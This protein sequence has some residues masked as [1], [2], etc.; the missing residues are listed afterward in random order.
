MLSNEFILSPGATVEVRNW[1]GRGCRRAH[2]PIRTHECA[3]VPGC[4]Q[5]FEEAC[6][7]LGKSGALQLS[8]DQLLVA[9]RGRTTL[10]F[11]T[12]LL[13]P[14]LQGYQVSRAATLCS[15]CLCTATWVTCRA[16]NGWA[17]MM[18]T[19]INNIFMLSHV[20]VQSYVS[21]SFLH[22]TNQPNLTSKKLHN[23]TFPPKKINF[24]QISWYLY[25]IFPWPKYIYE[26]KTPLEMYIQFLFVV[27]AS[28]LQTVMA[29]WCFVEALQWHRVW[30]SHL[31]V[32]KVKCHPLVH[33]F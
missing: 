10:T 17:D 33:A 6:Y 3:C 30:V 18:H 8:Q 22:I 7:L 26:L 21:L 15:V 19:W 1:I 2:R 29:D 25:W 13:D 32:N 16:G 4:W 14:F 12:S 5:D 9:E 23:F 31:V 24:L 27:P 20:Y 11:L 28:I